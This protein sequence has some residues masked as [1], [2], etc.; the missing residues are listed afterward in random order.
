M[1]KKSG[2]RQKN[3]FFKVVNFKKIRR[4]LPRRGAFFFIGKKIIFVGMIELQREK[5]NKR[6]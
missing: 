5:E 1:D 2:K 3:A 6:D 4:A